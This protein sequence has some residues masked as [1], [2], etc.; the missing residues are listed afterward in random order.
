MLKAK[1]R[2]IKDWSTA[3]Q[4]TIIMSLIIIVIGIYLTDYKLVLSDI[5]FSF[6]IVGYLF[7]GLYEISDNPSVA[8][9]WGAFFAF[10]LVGIRDFLKERRANKKYLVS[11]KK[12][13]EMYLDDLDNNIHY[14]DTQ[15]CH[16]RNHKVMGCALTDP[17]FYFDYIDIESIFRI[18][19]MDIQEKLFVIKKKQRIN[20]QSFEILNRFFTDKDINFTGEDFLYRGRKKSISDMGKVVIFIKEDTEKLSEKVR[21]LIVL[22]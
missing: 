22:I 4:K 19:S 18:K 16:I 11:I 21:E 14:L 5:I 13:L 15:V 1:I 2:N 10:I 17:L 12:S 7:G 9:F 20:N 6:A 8:A 3:N